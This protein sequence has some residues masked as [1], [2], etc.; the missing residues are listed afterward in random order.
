MIVLFGCIFGA[1]LGIVLAYAPAWYETHLDSK[2]KYTHSQYADKDGFDNLCSSV[3]LLFNECNNCFEN[4]EKKIIV[5]EN[6]V[7]ELE[8]EVR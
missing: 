3:E 7:E 5:L 8:K 1:I 4:I 2:S 6:R